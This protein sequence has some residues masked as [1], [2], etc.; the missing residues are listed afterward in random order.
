MAQRLYRLGLACVRRRAVVVLAWSALLIAAFVGSATLAATTVSTFEIPGQESTTA[1]DLLREKFGETAGSGSAQVVVRAA[2]LTDP[3]TAAKVGDL[4]GDLAS[5]PGVA[6]ASDPLDP[7]GGALSEDRTVA[8]STVTYRVRAPEITDAQRGALLDAVERARADGLTVDVRGTALKPPASGGGSAEAIGVVVAFLVLVLTF[9]SLVVAGMNL[10]TALVGVGIGVFGITALTGFVELQSTTPVLAVMLGLA[11]GI[12]YALFI[13]SR[14]RQELGDGAPVEQAAATA[15]A[16]AGS[17]VLTAGLTVAVALA[18]LT[19]AGIPFLTQMGLAAAA[20][21]VLTVAVAVTLVPAML[22]FVSERA[23]PGRPRRVRIGGGERR[24]VSG[25]ARRVV[26]SPRLCLVLAVSALVVVALPVLS[27]R[28][29]LTSR[30]DVGS[31]QATAERVLAD[32]FGE[33]RIAPLLVLVDGAASVDRAAEVR[34]RVAALPGVAVAAPPRPNGDGSAALITVIP[35]HGADDVA[36]VDL[37]HGIRALRADFEGVDFSVTGGTAVSIDVSQQLTDALLT[38]VLLVAGLAMVLLVLV[39]RSVLV[40]VVGVLGFLLT[41]SA[42]LGA[43]TAVFQWGVLAEVV[44]AEPTGP[45]MSLAPI[46]IVAIL[47]GLAMDY[48]IFLVSRI[49]E[50]RTGGGD[51]REAVALGFT[52]A[53]P[54]IIAA[55]AIMFAVFAGFVPDSESTIKPISF[56]LAVGV[57]LDAIVLRLVVVPAALALLGDAAWRLPRWLRGLPSPE[58]EASTS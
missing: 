14:F 6:T 54:V 10:L 44:N 32:Q 9:G 57:L 3:A 52:R 19:V 2:A 39:S 29:S 37:V 11:V 45:L 13:I 28:T 18:G 1:L 46:L 41:A 42:T 36:T 7:A 33:G 49:R 51:P 8:Y 56:A 47:F 20:T 31:T 34:Q 25:W 43:T 58:L 16:T 21:V 40:P 4:V 17:A 50:A 23:N 24:F 48:Q 5:L 53:A 27:T 12:D 15:V 55:A 26:E 22:G 30:P 38:Y 35:R